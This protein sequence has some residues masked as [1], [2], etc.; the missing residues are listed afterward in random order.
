MNL[1]KFHA[2]IGKLQKTSVGNQFGY[3][4]DIFKK[5]YVFEVGEFSFSLADAAFERLSVDDLMKKLMV[6]IQEMI[7]Q[8]PELFR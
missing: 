2:L 3:T 7:N 4:Y 8:Q 6:I 1:E 5:E